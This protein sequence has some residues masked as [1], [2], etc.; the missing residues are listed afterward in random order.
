MKSLLQLFA[1]LFITLPVIAQKIPRVIQLKLYGNLE[2]AE[3]NY[4]K[5]IGQRI[6]T[7]NQN[8]YSFGH[9]SPAINIS[10]EKYNQ[11]IEFSRLIIGRTENVQKL[12]NLDTNVPIPV[13]GERKTALDISM[14]YEFNYY[15]KSNSSRFMPQI[16]IGVKPYFISTKTTPLTSANIPLSRM[17]AGN[18]VSI[19]PRIVI[20]LNKNVFL[21]INTPIGILDSYYIREKEENPA[22]TPAEMK[23]SQFTTKFFQNWLQLRVGIGVNLPHD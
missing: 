23:S 19:V 6:V 22:F 18:T 10:R 17:I 7:T 3:F 20:N 2:Q 14:R 21:D 1:L 5:T 16:G 15:L 9:L 13:S 12:N 11:E 8:G 4:Q